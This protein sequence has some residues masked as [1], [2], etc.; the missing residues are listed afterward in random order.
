MQNDELTPEVEQVENQIDTT[1]EETTEQVDESTQDN[2]EAQVD[3][4][5]EALKWKNIAKRHERTPEPKKTLE[6]KTEKYLTR[7]EGILIAKGLD[8]EAIEQ[9]KVISKGK[10][11]TLL[12]AEKDPLFTTYFEKVQREKKIQQSKL[13]VSKGSGYSEPKKAFTS[14]LSREEHMKLWKETN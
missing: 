3:W 10:G 6:T 7:E 2:Q 1:V 13:G 12:E 5:S 9:I 14:G 11:V 8:D 4:K